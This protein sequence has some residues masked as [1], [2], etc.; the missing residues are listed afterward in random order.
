MFVLKG[1]TRLDGVD[2]KK[3]ATDLRSQIYAGPQWTDYL[4]ERVR[5]LCLLN[6]GYFKAVVKASTQQLPDKHST[7]QFVVTFDIDSG[8][9]Y[10]LGGITFKNNHAISNSK[11]LRDLFLT[12]DGDIFDPSAI[13]K[14]LDNLRYVYEEYGYINFTSVPTTTLDD[15]KKL[16]YLEVYM[17][18][19]KQF[20]VSSI[21]IVGADPQVL[22]DLLLTPGHVYNVRLVDLFLRRHLPGADVNDP[23]IQ[24]RTL[25]EPNGTVALTF[26]FRKWPE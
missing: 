20:Y 24:Q 7:H 16:G 23:R 9:Q 6:K 17:D 12:K 4:V 11:H 19:G 5:T 18:E 8:P 1:D 14:G 3:C 26:D 15:E 21:D 25:D 13:V 10:Q 22:N 2:L